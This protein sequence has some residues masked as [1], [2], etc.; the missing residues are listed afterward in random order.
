M[1]IAGK[2][3]V[4]VPLT[5]VTISRPDGDVT[6]RVAPFSPGFDERMATVGLGHYP[7]PP[8]VPVMNGK[9]PW[10]L[11]G[12]AIQQRENLD[13]PTYRAK[14][15]LRTVRMNALRVADALRKDPTIAFEATPPTNLDLA[16]WQAYA[17][18]L[19]GEINHPEHGFLDREIEAILK[20]A[21]NERVRVNVEEAKDEFLG[22]QSSEGVEDL[23]S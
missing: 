20:A 23:E 16:M 8:M 22:E 9:V 14:V 1:R 10:K 19:A 3:L 7:A 11:P 13:D 4:S 12:G 15:T 18:A 5:D 21:A 2:P 17:D 6:L